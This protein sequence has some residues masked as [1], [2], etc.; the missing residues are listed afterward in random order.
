MNSTLLQLIS[1]GGIDTEIIGKDKILFKKE[2]NVNKPLY[3]QYSSNKEITKKWGNELNINLN[4]GV[5]FISENFIKVKIPY[6]Q[7]FKTSETQTIEIDNFLINKILYDNHDTYLII[8]NKDNNIYYYLIP[9]FILDSKLN[10]NIENV[11]FSDIKE[12]FDESISYHLDDTTKISFIDFNGIDFIHNMVPLILTFGNN[13][14]RYYIDFLINNQENSQLNKSLLLPKSYNKYLGNLIDNKLFTDYQNLNHYDT[15]TEYYN[16]LSDEVKYFFKNFINNENITINE[17]KTNIPSSF[18]INSKE[19]LNNLEI[20]LKELNLIKNKNENINFTS[21]YNNNLIDSISTSTM[22]SFVALMNYFEKNIED[23]LLNYLKDSIIKN[24]LIIQYFLKNIYP[25]LDYSFLFFKKYYTLPNIYQY[26]YTIVD[27][28]IDDLNELSTN[29]VKNY[30]PVYILVNETD[31]TS[32]YYGKPKLFSKIPFQFDTTMVFKTFTN[33]NISL[34]ITNGVYT[35]SVDDTGNLNTNEL[36]IYI[37]TD[38]TKNEPNIDNVVSDTNIINEWTDNIKINMEKL[39]YDLNLEINLFSSFKYEYFLKEKI[40]NTLFK[41]INLTQKEIKDIFIGLK[42]YKERFELVN[43][44]PNYIDNDGTRYNDD[45]QSI[46]NLYPDLYKINNYP[47]DLYNVY[48]LCIKDFIDSINKYNY[49]K[50]NTFI[51]MFHN[52]LVLYF[53]KRYSKISTISDSI[54]NNFNGI[55]LYFNMDNKFYINKNI[56]R[57]NLI[58]LF[59]K[60]SYIGYLSVEPKTLLSHNLIKQDTTIF[61]DNFTADYT[62]SFNNYTLKTTYD[63]TSDYIDLIYSDNIIKI[64][65][66]FFNYCNFKDTLTKW[67]INYTILEKSINVTEYYINDIYLVLILPELSSNSPFTLTEITE[68]TVPLIHLSEYDS[69]IGSYNDYSQTNMPYNHLLNTNLLLTGAL[70]NNKR[71]ELYNKETNVNKFIYDFVIHLDYDDVNKQTYELNYT[72]FIRAEKYSGINSLIKL[73]YE[74]TETFDQISYPYTLEQNKDNLISSISLLLNINKE[75]VIFKNLIISEKTSSYIDF[76]FLINKEFNVNELETLLNTTIT[77]RY[78][79]D[80][81]LS[82]NTATISCINIKKLNDV[83]ETIKVNSIEEFRFGYCYEIKDESGDVIN[84]DYN[85]YN[86]VYMD[87][88]KLP[89]YQ[90]EITD[91]DCIYEISQTFPY[92]YLDKTS[93]VYTQYSSIISTLNTFTL[94][95]TK[96]ISM[97]IEDITDDYI[98]FY[99]IDTA[100]K[101]SPL[102]V[103]IYNNSYL[104]NIYSYT[105]LSNTNISI[106]GDFMFQQP[107]IF[108]QY[109]KDENIPTYIF[110]NIPDNSKLKYYSSSEM[111]LNDIKI[112]EIISLSS[113]QLNRDL[114]T[115]E[116]ISTS[117]DINNLYNTE[118]VDLPDY[119]ELYIDTYDLYN[120]I[121]KKMLELYDKAFSTYKG[122]IIDVIEKSYT[123]YYNIYVNILNNIKSTEDFGITTNK[124]YNNS[125][126][127]NSFK[128]INNNKQYNINFENYDIV[129]YDYFTQFAS[130]LYSHTNINNQHI[131]SDLLYFFNLNQKYS[132]N[133]YIINF[134]W[135]D[136]EPRF[137]INNN[138]NK[139][140]E[141]ANTFY[142]NQITY[143]YNNNTINKIVNSNYSTE[144]TKIG[145]EMLLRGNYQKKIYNIV[146]SMFTLLNPDNY[147]D[148]IDYNINKDIINNYLTFKN[149]DELNSEIIYIESYIDN[150]KIP[151][152]QAG[153]NRYVTNTILDLNNDN[154]IFVE[155]KINNTEYDNLGYVNVKNNKIKNSN[156]FEETF[157]IVLI[158]NKIYDLPINNLQY[159]YYVYGTSNSGPTNG[160]SGY[161]YPLSLNKYNDDDH[162]HTFDEYPNITFYMVSSMMN[163]YHDYISPSPPSGFHNFDKVKDIDT[164]LVTSIYGNIY[165]LTVNDSF[166]VVNVD[167]FDLFYYKKIKDNSG[168]LES[169]FNIGNQ[170]KYFIKINNIICYAKYNGSYLEVISRK[171]FII[172]D[173]IEIFYLDI[174]V[175]NDPISGLPYNDEYIYNIITSTALYEIELAFTNSFTL[176][177]F[178]IYDSNKFNYHT[179]NFDSNILTLDDYIIT[180]GTANYNDTSKIYIKPVNILSALL[181]YIDDGSDDN[182][183]LYIHPVEKQLIE[184]VEIVNK[185][186]K[187]YNTF[188][189]IKWSENINNYIFINNYEIQVKNLQD[190]EIEDG[191]Y[192]LYYSNNDTKPNNIP[193]TDIYENANLISDT[194]YY[195]IYKNQVT[196]IDVTNFENN[197]IIEFNN[198]KYLID[199]FETNTVN[200]KD[201]NDNKIEID[202]YDILNSKTENRP[203]IYTTTESYYTY[204]FYDLTETQS[205][206]NMFYI[207]YSTIT[208]NTMEL[209]KIIFDSSHSS[210]TIYISNT[211]SFINLVNNGNNNYT[212]NFDSSKS[213]NIDSNYIAYF[214]T[215]LLD[216]NGFKQNIENI[217]FRFYISEN[218]FEENLLIDGNEITEPLYLDAS[219]VQDITFSNNPSLGGGLLRYIFNQIKTS[220][221]TKINNYLLNTISLSE[222]NEY[223]VITDKLCSFNEINSNNVNIYDL[224]NTRIHKNYQKNWEYIDNN[225]IDN[226]NIITNKILSSYVKNSYLPI[227][228]INNDEMHFNNISDYNDQSITLCIPV[229]FTNAD[230]FIYPYVPLYINVNIS[231]QKL[232]NLDYIIYID[233]VNSMNLERNEVIKIN[234]KVYFIKYYSEYYRGFISKLICSKTALYIN[235]TGYYSFGKFNNFYD[236][237]KYL[238]NNN[239]SKLFKLTSNSNKDLIYGDLYIERNEMKRYDGTSISNDSYFKIDNGNNVNMLY[240]DSKLYYD[241]LKIK[242]IVGMVFYNNDTKYTIS[243]VEN[244]YITFSGSHSF[245]NNNIIS[246]YFPLNV[247]TQETIIITNNTIS[248]IKN[249]FIEIDDSIIRVTNYNISYDNYNGSAGVYNLDNENIYSD[250]NNQYTMTD[251]TIDII[252]NEKTAYELELI[253]DD[254]EDYISFSIDLNYRNDFLSSNIKYCYYQDI[255]INGVTFK[256][257]DFNNKKIYINETPSTFPLKDTIDNVYKCILSA[258]NVNDTFCIM[259]RYKLSNNYTYNYPH[260]NKNSTNN[261]NILFYDSNELNT[262]TFN[263]TE[264]YGTTDYSS[265]LPYN[266][267]LYDSNYKYV[268]PLKSQKYNEMKKNNNIWN[269]TNKKCFIEDFSRYSLVT[270]TE[271]GYDYETYIKLE[272]LDMDISEYVIIEEIYNNNKYVHYVNL[273][274]VN[275]NFKIK[276]NNR[277]ENI[278]ESEFY[279]HRLIPV[280]ITKNNY[281]Q[282][283]EPN[284]IHNRTINSNAKKLKYKVFIKIN[285]TDKPILSNGKWYYKINNEADNFISIPKNKTTL[286]FED[287]L[288]T[289]DSN[290]KYLIST[291]LFKETDNNTHLYF[292]IDNYIESI[293]YKY[294]GTKDSFDLSKSD[295]YNIFTGNDNRYDVFLNEFNENDFYNNYKLINTINI[296]KNNNNQYLLFYNN[297]SEITS[298]GD[299]QGTNYFNNTNEINNSYKQTDNTYLLSL[300]SI[301]LDVDEGINNNYN[302]YR[303]VNY[304]N[305]DYFLK[306]KEISISFPSFISLLNSN[307]IDMIHLTNYVKPWNDWVFLSLYNNDDLVQN[308]NNFSISYNGSNITNN[309]DSNCYFTDTEKT[310][311]ETFLKNTFEYKYHYY[312]I[313]TELHNLESYLLTIIGEIINQEY[314]WNNI[315]IVIKDICESYNGD[316][317]WTYYNNTIMTNNNDVLEITTYPELFENGARK[318]YLSN[319]IS[320]SD[321]NNVVT[322]SRNITDVNNNINSFLLNSESNNN[323]FSMDVF[324][325]YLKN[326]NDDRINDLNFENKY[327]TLFNH[328][329]CNGIKFFINKNY[330]TFVD[331]KV[332][333]LNN[334]NNNFY[335]LTFNNNVD[336]TNAGYY[337]DNVFNEKNFG[338]LSKSKIKDID[339][340]ISDKYFITESFT[341]NNI[342][343]FKTINNNTLDCNGVYSYQINFNDNTGE[344]LNSN[345]E[346]TLEYQNETIPNPTIYSDSIIFNSPN[347]LNNIDDVSIISKETY[348]ISEYTL[349][350]TK[351]EITTEYNNNITINSEIYYEND[352]LKLISVSESG[353]AVI[354]DKLI[355]ELLNLRIVDNCKLTK[356]EISGDNTILYFSSNITSLYLTDITLIELNGKMY[357]LEYDG[358]N[359]YINDKLIL[360]KNRLYRVSRMIKLNNSS[361]NAFYVSEIT[362]DRNINEYFYYNDN[363]FESNFINDEMLIVNTEIINSNKLRLTHINLH[364]NDNNIIHKYRIR[365]SLNY[366]INNIEKLDKYLY[367]LNIIINYNNLS[368]LEIYVNDLLIDI[369]N[370]YND[371]LDF[372][373]NTLINVNTI[374]TYN[375]IIKYNYAISSYTIIDNKMTI[376]IPNDFIYKSN[377]T[378]YLNGNVIVNIYVYSDN[379]VLESTENIID[380]GSFYLEESKTFSSGEF[381]ITK[382]QYNSLFNI[383]LNNNFNPA[384]KSDNFIPYVSIFDKKNNLFN[385]EY[386]YYVTTTDDIIFGDN[387]IIFYKDES[388]KFEIIMIEDEGDYYS[389]K[390][391]SYRYFEENVLVEVYTEDYYYNFTST[392][393]KYHHNIVPVKYFK[394][395]D[396]KNIY[397]YVES[398][399]IDNYDITTNIT[400]N[401]YYLFTQYSDIIIT[402]KSY[403]NPGFNKFIPNQTIT[404]TNSTTYQDIQ[405]VE[406]IELKFFEYIE[407][408]IN[409]KVIE[410]LDYNCYKILTSYYQ[411]KYKNSD[412]SELTK[413]RNE[414]GYYTFNLPLL[415]FFTK[416]PSDYLPMYLLKNEKVKIKFK[417]NKLS[418]LI[419]KSQYSNYKISKDV[420]PI[421][422]YFYS[423]INVTKDELD[424][425]N[426]IDNKLMETIYP[427]QT[428]ILNNQYENNSI[429]LSSRVKELFILIE[430]DNIMTTYDYDSWYSEYKTNYDKYIEIINNS[431]YIYDI[432]DYYIFRQA[433]FEIN[434]NSNRVKI[435]KSH[436]LLKNYDTRYLVYLDEKYLDYINENLNNIQSSFS[437][438]LTI[439]SLYFNNIYKNIKI[440]IKNKIIDNIV[441][442]IDG[443][444]ISPTLSS[445]YYEYV[446]PYFTGNQIK[447][448]T[449]LFNFNLENNSEQPNGML[450]F[451]NVKNFNIRTKQNFYENVKVKIIVKEY[452]FIN[453]K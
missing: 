16:I 307:S 99:I 404:N 310:Y 259:N 290:N 211:N 371:Y 224:N 318:Y 159:K 335:N 190:L 323:G 385:Y 243:T 179:N 109:S 139:Y 129:N 332:N 299:L 443:R 114:I 430:T 133:K 83:I 20:E 191:N 406:D 341:N 19:S 247:F 296:N 356:S 113:N 69:I 389:V 366:K 168:I 34:N 207:D 125:L 227:I 119:S 412:F 162:F 381:K 152:N 219:N 54:I 298:I 230:I 365:Q 108:K 260:L 42:V 286:Y 231:A 277:F 257:I 62:D 200:F 410:R 214:E 345:N 43:Y 347:I 293:R 421:I 352:K 120:I 175:F 23:D 349:F 39:N 234:N 313:L 38:N 391:G 367:N 31:S 84:I 13:Y 267:S 440:D 301:L 409:D 46:L 88:I 397:V 343:Y 96:N 147:I 3:K 400:S 78:Y 92:I 176:T 263:F 6:F 180:Y 262:Y 254:S 317:D 373:L 24:P 395:I 150:E 446:R 339:F 237:N 436:Y 86:N 218:W 98:K 261:M 192:L 444:V 61:N 174:G 364:E 37:T 45:Y 199:N 425:L 153:Q 449:L 56:I 50:N 287:N 55:L 357:K 52:K 302:I 141:N 338:L 215:Y 201:Y 384:N 57:N 240:K 85:D 241:S 438:K 195:D 452:K 134:P 187:V 64:N 9:I 348:T 32:I 451:S 405:F 394:N 330:S 245:T 413:I 146:F 411:N 189:N 26:E 305:N 186:V 67:Q 250:F 281:I 303:D 340:T 284:V 166:I 232:N 209:C 280:R 149:E 238:L 58:E 81:Q 392:I 185:D 89:A 375:V 363:K 173:T 316:N 172:Y 420:E 311:I 130:T 138:V 220:Y 423:F 105:S 178:I 72:Y 181:F 407:F 197:N 53:Y 94:V 222:I 236:K 118:N 300:D 329:F 75:Q 155:N 10:Y 390:I 350:G 416:N 403:K 429:N 206:D 442:E 393:K 110:Y 11:E 47:Q 212:I 145:D 14:D 242:L 306:E 184:P 285:Y 401:N 266:G 102:T 328:D 255:L 137:K 36:K 136:F 379:V 131:K 288:F 115:D 344:I 399:N 157:D 27:E 378:Y 258:G 18:N 107:I 161:F 273:E 154:K 270:F 233:N 68:F 217:I 170:Y 95:D 308:L 203:I 97:R 326:F 315:D 193:Y 331:D 422:E 158:D 358:T 359:Y 188:D 256:V 93:T 216:D 82:Q 435:F 380:L 439:L 447:E 322:I 148:Y 63:F 140:F 382:P 309:T 167:K 229:D 183:N 235:S 165:G 432:D 122:D 151:V 324:I 208:G 5:N 283:L 355:D 12:Y 142:N 35:L 336:I 304:I 418:N 163:H 414:N 66:V 408:I 106:N 402:N 268:Y 60:K 244:N 194:V 22:D 334:L 111:F 434:T 126:I 251:P 377:Y 8:V 264:S 49:F 295:L 144:S 104:P 426:E 249:G 360:R 276:S 376:P 228:L 225:N 342:G 448:N 369:N 445:D 333:G 1:R 76:Y 431:G 398:Q 128:T 44:E 453:F 274:I 103:N 248:N 40:I 210:E 387:I 272:D 252:N 171:D 346:Y 327:N 372:Y 297:N 7:M 79:V 2:F 135:I 388:I 441:F 239:I 325:T 415:L 205:L 121:E 433:D 4:N 292:T 354:Y 419:D 177:D 226:N 269:N 374:N 314:F 450:D 383:T 294:I 41:N 196:D 132:T 417:L 71:V 116:L 223:Y 312:D 87:I 198:K 33:K 246:F 169:I 204:K 112:N 156:K 386:Y 100:I 321:I 59:N 70:N 117:Y 160:I 182:I 361:I 370:I 279:L 29:L 337:I 221:L 353:I 289:Y 253:K 123:E 275:N 396:D 427:Y 90:I 25:T 213:W 202:I 77:T 91:S 428:I 319:D 73:T 51:K 265:L 351:Y 291:Y 65:K 28:D 271:T 282:I 164:N 124:L 101:S 424:D 74:L 278:D 320:I 362:L 127:L 48:L 80:S 15:L 21:S 143:C 17:S 437:N 368:N 30:Y